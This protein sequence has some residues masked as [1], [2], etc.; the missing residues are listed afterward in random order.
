MNQKHGK[1][2]WTQSLHLT[3]NNDPNKYGYSGYDIRF[4]AL[5]VFSITGEFGKNVVIF[6]L[7][8]SSSVHVDNKKK[9]LNSW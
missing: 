5:S 1:T 4:N 7:D 6:V 2:I 3:K 8:N 9:Y